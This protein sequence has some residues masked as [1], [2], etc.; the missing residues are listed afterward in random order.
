[1]YIRGLIPRNSTELAKA[2]PMACD[3]VVKSQGQTYLQYFLLL[4]TR[5]PFTLFQW[6]VFIV[7]TIVA[8]IM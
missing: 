6:R 2:V 7:G 8:Y 4:V 3:I 1:M 5:T